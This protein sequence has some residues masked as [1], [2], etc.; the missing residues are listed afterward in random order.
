MIEIQAGV[1]GRKEHT[2]EKVQLGAV[3][4][5]EESENLGHSRTHILDLALLATT[6]SL[7]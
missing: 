2:H 7:P 5:Q 1:E 3:A 6:A 4:S